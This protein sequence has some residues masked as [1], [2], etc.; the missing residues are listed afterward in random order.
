MPP[1]SIFLRG[2][3]RPKAIPSLKDLVRVYK[4]E[5]VLLIE[6]LVHSNKIKDL[7]YVLGYDGSFVVDRDGRSGGLA[8]FWKST[9]NCNII[10]FSSNFINLQVHDTMRGDW[11]LTSF[12]GY[13][14]SARRRQSWNLLRDLASMSTD[15]WCIIG[16]FNDLLSSDDKK[17]GPERP[18]WLYNGFRNAVSDC[19][20][21]DM[22]LEG[23]QYTWFK[24]LGTNRALE[25]RLD[26]AMHTHAW[27]LMF[28]KA[29]LINLVAATSDHSP[30]LLKLEHEPYI[31]PKRSFRFENSWLLDNSLVAMI[32]SNWPY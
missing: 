2:L 4:P 10:N 1:Y 23:Y 15:P 30:I 24:S 17:G 28:P 9:F 20:L 6:T 8:V 29:R 18:A 14:D 3:G 31:Q 21:L 22:P 16:D 7:C 12:W 11:R 32:T 5:I 26:R 25:E 27:S 13:S 19:S